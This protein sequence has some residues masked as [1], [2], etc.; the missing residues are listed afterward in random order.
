MKNFKYIYVLAFIC[1]FVNLDAQNKGAAEN[2]T[3]DQLERSDTKREEV[4]RYFGYETLLMRYF[5]AP[6]DITM[7][8]N[9]RGNFLDVGFIY[10]LFL[11]IL[12]LLYFKKERPFVLFVMFL[13]LLMLILS[14]SNSYVYDSERISLVENRD[15]KLL[16]NPKIDFAKDPTGAFLLQ[17]YKINN[18]IYKPISLAIS[19]ISGQKDYVTY[20]IIFTLFSLLSYFLLKRFQSNKESSKYKIAFIVWVYGFLWFLLSS[21]IIWYGYLML[22][23][24]LV[25][26][27]V[28]IRGLDQSV[29]YHKYLRGTLYSLASIW[30][31]VAFINRV[32]N[33]NPAVSTEHQGKGMYNPSFFHYSSGVFNYDQTLE[34]LYPNLSLAIKRINRFD[35]SLVYR[36]G[37]SFTYFIDNNHE[38]V[39][40]DNQLGFF[41]NL[42]QKYNDKNSVTLALKASGFKFII[43]DLY[44]PT[45]DRTP[46]RTLTSKYNLFMNF[47]YDNQNMRLIGTDRVL[48]SEESDQ[49]RKFGVYGDIINNGSYAIYEILD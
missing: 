16:A 11:P 12:F 28:L 40:I 27:F 36:V 37:T 5:T 2:T 42:V 31:I 46:E 7:N 45:I 47:I 29:A 38:R 22:L 35:Q 44:T 34:S 26:I 21:G 17:T 49:K 48:R 13:L 10:L 15:G 20:P 33:I 3:N 19:K 18:V 1:L 41:K 23:L 30:I 39:F 4:Q 8:V 32:S 9:E 14:M 24:G 25:L 43:I 6:Y